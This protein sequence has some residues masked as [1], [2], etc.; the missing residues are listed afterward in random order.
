MKHDILLVTPPVFLFADVNDSYPQQGVA[1]LVGFLRQAGYRAPHYD[2]NVHF[3]RRMMEAVELTPLAGL[4]DEKAEFPWLRRRFLSR[5]IPAWLRRWNATAR[6]SWAPGAGDMGFRGIIEDRASVVAKFVEDPSNPFLEFFTQNHR[7]DEALAGITR[8]WVGISVVGPSQALPSFTLSRAIKLRRPD[9][10]VIWGGPWAGF[11][12]E[13]IVRERAL[14]RWID[15]IGTGE[16]ETTLVRLLERTDSPQRWSEVENLV[17]NR[18]PHVGLRTQ[19]Q[20]E[21]VNGLA[22]PDFGDFDRDAYEQRHRAT[23]SFSRGCYWSRCAFCRHVAREKD[24][25]RPRSTAH[26]IRDL[27]DLT[28]RQGFHRFMLSDTAVSPSQLREVSSAILDAG[29]KISVGAF[30]RPEANFTREDFALACRAGI[31]NITFGVETVDERVSALMCRGNRLDPQK[32]ITA[33]LEAG[34]K[35]LINLIIGF[36]TET[37]A[38]I[39]RT[40]AFARRWRDKIQV[41][42]APFLLFRGAVLYT[43]AQRFGIRVHETE[44]HRFRLHLDYDCATGASP[45]RVRQLYF[46]YVNESGQAHAAPPPTLSDNDMVKARVGGV[47]KAIF[48]LPPVMTDAYAVAALHHAQLGFALTA[49]DLALLRYCQRPTTVG[50]LVAV[51]GNSSLGCDPAVLARQR[52]TALNNLG[53]LTVSSLPA[54]GPVAGDGVLDC[55]PLPPAPT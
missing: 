21:D 23:Y 11:F 40:L 27:R 20:L 8:G 9:L 25:Y 29:L 15:A 51:L 16:G 10:H 18:P 34:T 6:P 33:A 45:E 52:L 2:A 36:P 12:A 30:A 48:H 26:I 7:L 5:A 4:A 35:V 55:P 50:Q 39:E 32:A 53:Y 31:G 38:E 46:G 22:T 42:V 28:E 49:P 14:S 43:E 54:Q 41:R 3:T 13:T 37:E 47:Y 1:A 24:R 44:E 17:C 19:A